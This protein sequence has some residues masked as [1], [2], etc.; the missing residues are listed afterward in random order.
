VIHAI[1][2]FSISRKNVT[3]PDSKPG[4]IQNITVVTAHA[5]WIP[6]RATLGR[7]D[8]EDAWNQISL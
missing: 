3:P 2:F 7:N 8:V 1:Y 6:A 5:R 4:G